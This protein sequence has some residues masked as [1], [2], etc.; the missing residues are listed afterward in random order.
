MQKPRHIL[1]LIPL[2]LVIVIDTMGVGL[3]L[4]VVSPLFLQQNGGILPAGT[5]LEARNLLYAAALGGFS[6]LMFFGAPFLGDLSDFLG[7]KKV[8]IICL[9]ATALTLIVGAF[10]I[11]WHSVSLLILGRCL[12][13]FVAGSQ[14]I[15]QAAIADISTQENKAVNMSMMVFA[16]CIG[17]VIG[18][19]IGAYFANSDLIA[20]FNPSTPF[21][22]AA[23]LAFFNAILLLLFF[24]ETY[25]PKPGKQLKFGKAVMVFLDAFTDKK[26]QLLSVVLLCMEL[27]FAIYFV[28]ISL[29]L[30]QMFHYDSTRIGHFMSFLGLCWAVTF[31]VIVRIALKW[32]SLRQMSLCGMFVMGLCFILSL[33]RSELILWLCVIPLAIFNGLTFTSLLALFSNTADQDSQGWAMGA[34]SAVIAAAWAIGALLAGVLGSIYLFLPFICA[35]IITLIGFFLL[36]VNKT[37]ENT[38]KNNNDVNLK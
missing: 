24:Q 34:S 29:Y 12:S 17:F 30:V 27:G 7:R 11:L 2:F 21:F 37:P 14:P 38:S 22:V 32:M 35:G 26:I 28:F 19:M 31:L 33:I 1:T 8:L 15:A 9:A 36:L 20:W 16:G 13:G 23:A 3:I 18:P 10:G 25:Q 6:V 5:S 4:P